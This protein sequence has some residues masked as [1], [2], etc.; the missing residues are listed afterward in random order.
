MTARFFSEQLYPPIKQTLQRDK[1][2]AFFT[3][4]TKYI[5]SPNVMTR[6]E[7]NHPGEAIFFSEE[8]LNG[9]YSSTGVT[10]VD[11]KRCVNSTPEIKGSWKIA[12]KPYFW[13]VILAIRWMV[14]TKQPEERIKMTV[15]FLA[16]LVYGGPG[17]QYKFFRR[18][19]QPNAMAYAVN[20]LS[21][22]FILRQEKTILKVLIRS[23]WSS[24]TRSVGLLTTGNDAD[25]VSY[26]V[27]VWSRLNGV[28]KSIAKHY[29]DVYN[30]GLYLNQSTETHDDGTMRDRETDGGSVTTLADMVT[31]KFLGETL[32]PH[33]I[34]LSAKIADTPPQTLVLAVGEL[35]NTEGEA[36]RELVATLIE[37]YFDEMKGDRNG[38]RT[39]KFIE[40]AATIY[41]RSNTL[42]Q[43][44]ETIK[45]R[46]DEL[47]KRNS[48]S[49]MRTNRE[50]TRSSFRKG[51]YYVLVLFI[52]SKA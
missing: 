40:F 24:H 3:H 36:I 52:Q 19:Y 4:I 17:L 25:L 11:V 44:V 28:I 27:S 48:Q 31:E 5:N 20:S 51:L 29:Y 38:I 30:K 50:A 32:P 47:L 6:L 43:R 45:T 33:I 46:L 14:E 34:D 15:L 9:I 49:Y 39:R 21:E 37:I 13:P 26:F 18:F 23:G 8:I 22:R 41:S 12:S 7:M 1:S 42:D 10:E 35:R 16:I 2:A